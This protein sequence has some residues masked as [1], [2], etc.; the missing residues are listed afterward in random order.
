MNSIVVKD[1][2]YEYINRENEKPSEALNDISFV[3]KEGEFVAIVGR[4]GS[5]KSTL[6]RHLNAL[7]LPTAGTVCIF[8]KYT[9][10]EDL[11]WEI[12]SQLGMVFQNPDNQ[13]VATTV[14]EDVAFGPENLGIEPADIRRR[15]DESLEKVNMSKYLN[16][17]PYMLS[18]GQKQRVAIAGVL[19]MEPKCLVLDEATSMLDPIGRNDVMKILKK[20]NIDE[21]ITIVLITHHMDEAAQ[22]QR[23]ILIDEG[24]LVIEGSPRAVFAQTETIKKAGMDIP[25]VS[26]FYVSAVDAG[27]I[28]KDQM[29]VVLD[30]SE[31]LFS[32]YC[33]LSKKHATLPK[34]DNNLLE[35]EKVIEVRDLSYIYM[36]DAPLEK[37]ALTDVSLDVYKG[38]ILGIIGHTG[39]GKSTLIQHLNGLLTPKSGSINV[40]GVVPKG[41]ALK[42]LRKK[43]GLIFQNPEDQLF[44]ET[45]RKDIAFGLRK[46]GLSDLEIEERVTEAA[47]TTG[48]P[49]EVLDK[50]PFELSGGQKRRVAIAGVIAMEPEVLVLDEPTAGLDPAGSAEIY[51]FLLKLR[52]ERDTTIII[53]S[54]T[55]E[56]IA[57][58]CDKVAVMDHGKLVL[59]GKTR[60]VFNNKDFL[61]QIGLDVPQI[62]ELFYRLNKKDPHI[63]KDILTVEEAISELKRITMN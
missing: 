54:H 7:L 4:N 26:S 23:V 16:H 17:S 34:L 12:R 58:Y 13:I 21:G 28:Q 11:I 14:E 3:V 51:Q 1:V 37:Q 44:E 5:G 2:K 52:Q 61:S 45:V 47:L 25:Q 46:R 33:F 42:E 36:P 57:N 38:E 6:A 60:E 50:S 48:L 56:D 24:K 63:R 55:M 41:K 59:V 8:G 9:N 18:G 15:I 30:E 62:T 31:D 53:V 19:A 20:L 27:I 49:L 10:A 22:A 43:V 40:M 35:K 32:K 29:P 39:S